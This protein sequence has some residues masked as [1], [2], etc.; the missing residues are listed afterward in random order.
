RLENPSGAIGL[1]LTDGSAVAGVPASDA[2]GAIV[3]NAADAVWS[4]LLAQT[5]KRLMNDVFLLLGQRLMTSTGD[6]VTYAQYYPAAMRAIELLRPPAPAAPSLPP[7][8]KPGRSTAR[9]A[10]TSTSNSRAR[11][12]ASTSRRPAAAF[13]SC[14]STPPAATARNGATCSSGARSPT[15]SA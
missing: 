15:I 12:T 1:T 2:P 3:L 8:P 5:P 4:E 6:A 13:R 7:P 14:S 10:A 11:I 9:S